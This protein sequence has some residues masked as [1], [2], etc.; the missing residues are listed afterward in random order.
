MKLLKLIDDKLES[1]LINFLLANIV[2]WVFVQVVMRYVFSNSL[3]WSEEF[4][5][6]CF[7]WFIWIGV[8]YGFKTRKHISVTALINLFPKKVESVINVLVNVIILWFMVKLCIYGVEQVNNPIIARQSSI[9]LEFPFT[10]TRVG[11]QWLYA[12]LPFGALLSAL[13]L[14]QNTFY[15]IK[16]LINKNVES[17]LLEQGR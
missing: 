14:T 6:W 2:I 1:W 4:V 8:S 3:P 10:D 11:M 13:R 15:D 5:R 16:S 12:S 7:I 9:V 17:S